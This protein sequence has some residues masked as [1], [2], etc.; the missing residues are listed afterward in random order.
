MVFWKALVKRYP[1]TAHQ[2]CWVH[3]AANVLSIR[4]KSVQ[5]KDKDALHDIWMA[6]TRD[7]A[8]QASDRTLMRFEAKGAFESRLRRPRLRIK[9]RL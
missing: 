8:Y 9:Y 6:E 3:K 2:R 7:H 1:N 4:P 5:P